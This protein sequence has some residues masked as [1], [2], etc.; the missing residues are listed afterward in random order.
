MGRT[1]I[2]ET[3]KTRDHTEI[4]LKYFKVKFKISKQKDNSTKLTFNGPYEIQAK[5]IFVAGDPSSAAFFIVAALIV[6]NSKISL[7]NVCLNKTRIE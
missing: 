4:L 5:N 1:S 2:I 3:R 7:K 6:P